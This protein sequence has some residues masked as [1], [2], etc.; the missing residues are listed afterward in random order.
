MVYIYKQ[1]S[2]CN[3]DKPQQQRSSKREYQSSNYLVKLRVPEERDKIET[4]EKITPEQSA[5]LGVPFTNTQAWDA[6]AAFYE[7]RL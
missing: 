7:K 2:H 4:F 6:F 1:T 5:E 3:E